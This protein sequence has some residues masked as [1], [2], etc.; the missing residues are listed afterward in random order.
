MKKNYLRRLFSG[1]SEEEQAIIFDILV[2]LTLPVENLLI[3]EGESS[4]TFY[5][6]LTG[7]VEVFIS[8]RYGDKYTLNVLGN[9]SYFGELAFL[10]VQDSLVFFI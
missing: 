10:D 3:Q 8:N 7:I 5:I 1:L 9:D 2:L 6:L 4:K